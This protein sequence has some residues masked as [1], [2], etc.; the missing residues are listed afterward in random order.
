VGLDLVGEEDLGDAFELNQGGI[1]GGHGVG[2]GEGCGLTNTPGGV[3]VT[4]I[5]MIYDWAGPEAQ[6]GS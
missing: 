2:S 3:A 4:E 6:S 1:F 5:F